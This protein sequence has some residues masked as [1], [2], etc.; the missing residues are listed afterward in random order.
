MYKSLQ[1]GRAVAAILVVLFHLGGAIA[2]EKYFHSPF[3][4][5]PFSFGGAGVEFF[6][7]LS[8]FIIFAVHK[9]DIFQPAQF[10][11]FVKKRVIRIYPTYWI[12]FLSVYILAISSSALRGTVPHDLFLV[13]RS[14]LLIPQDPTS[15]GGTGAPVLIVAWTLQYEMLFYGFFAVMILSRTATVGLGVSWLL[16]YVMY[17]GDVTLSF[18]LSFLVKDHILLFF[19]GMMVAKA[20]TSRGFDVARP[21]LWFSVGAVFFSVVAFEKV[22]GGGFLEDK[23]VL[24]YGVASAL[25]VFGLVKAEDRGCVIGG[26][27]W[28]QVLGDSSYA[29]YLIHY[30]LISILCKFS[31]LLQLKKWGGV[32]ALL[33]YGLIFV[34]CLG[35]AV[36]FHLW[37]ER[38]LTRYLRG[39]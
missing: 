34:A 30:P 14:L 37:L 8:G 4:A 39:L 26:S 38:P 22:L 11:D 21:M 5:V 17:R 3:F 16:V 36:L 13:L 28:L 18:P 29:L 19:F 15:V 25:M 7:V 1:A 23:R 35:S 2:A 9:Q 10:G 20:C 32:G 31:M 6:F 24:L 12:L 33:S 27:K